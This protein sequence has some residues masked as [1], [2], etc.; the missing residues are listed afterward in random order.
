MTSSS[1]KTRIQ[2]DFSDREN[3]RLLRLKEKLDA[4]SYKEVIKQALHLIEVIHDEQA[5][6]NAIIIRKE[7]GQLIELKIII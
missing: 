1:N 2:V 7:D 4:G 6:G 5:K 3:E